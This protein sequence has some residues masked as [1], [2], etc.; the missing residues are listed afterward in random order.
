MKNKIK[1]FEKLVLIISFLFLFFGLYIVQAELGIFKDTIGR[2]SMFFSTSNT[3][4]SYGYCVERDEEGYL[5][6]IENADIEI[7][8]I[9]NNARLHYFDSAVEIILE[10]LGVDFSLLYEQ[11][12]IEKNQFLEDWE[13]RKN[14]EIERNRTELIENC[15]ICEWK[16]RQLEIER[17]N[18]SDRLWDWLSDPVNNL[19]LEPGSD[20]FREE[21][22]RLLDEYMERWNRRR[23]NVE[24]EC[25][26]C[27]AVSRG[28]FPGEYSI[29]LRYLNE[30]MNTL[31]Q[32]SID[33]Y[34][35][36][37]SLLYNE[38]IGRWIIENEEEWEEYVRAV[39]EDLMHQDGIWIEI[40]I[41]REMR[42]QRCRERYLNM[43]CN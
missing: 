5:R 10:E 25:Q 32:M 14:E 29:E 8:R 36:I 24:E 40:D 18:E 21:H 3:Y 28:I 2:A 42:Y 19:F 35:N 12:E 37:H 20:E 26:R 17:D 7:E 41:E 9:I 43:D 23:E 27:D 31:L 33:L 1:L 30:K 16:I 34:D 39:A 38:M 15:Q 4:N 11:Y 22:Q 6:C 13:N